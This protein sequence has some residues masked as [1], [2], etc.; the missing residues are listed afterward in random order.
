MRAGPV[1]AAA[2]RVVVP[3]DQHSFP[4]AHYGEPEYATFIEMLPI[5]PAFH[6]QRRNH[7]RRCVRLW[8]DL[9]EWFS[10]PLVERVARHSSKG[11]PTLRRRVSYESRSYLYYLALTDR[12]RLDYDWLLA[13]GDLRLAGVTGPLGIDLGID[14]LADEGRQ[15][16]FHPASARLAMQWTLGR[17]ALHTGIRDPAQLRTEH[18]EELLAAVRRFGERADVAEFYG[19]AARYR[20]SPSKAWITHLH[21]LGLVLYHRGQ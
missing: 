20:V 21:Q 17:I 15:L 18:V 12:V 13:L 11:P 7:Q 5:C 1:S 3:A 10:V 6:R 2:L 14:V 19:S 4:N 8:P 16:G 9:A